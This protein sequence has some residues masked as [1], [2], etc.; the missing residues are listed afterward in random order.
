MRKDAPKQ[1]FYS[2]TP[3]NLDNQ[4]HLNRPRI[5]RLLEQ[6]V[7]NQVVIVSAGAGYGKTYA[8]YS[9]MRNYPALICWIQLSERDNISE[10]FWENFISGVSLG[11]KSAA[12]RL[13]TM[14]FPETDRQFERYWSIPK[15]ETRTDAKY[16]FIYD[17]FH[18]LQN[19]GVLRF[20]EQ[21]ITSP[22][23]NITSILISRTEPALDLTKLQV[24]GLVSR[25][26]EDDLRFTRE[27]MV[28]Y[29]H[30]QNI[31]PS[32]QTVAAIYDDAEGWAFA[33]HLAGLSLKNAAPGM[34]Y[35]PQAMRAN[36][37]KLIATEI[38]A[39][40]PVSLQRFLIKLSLIEH[41]APELLEKLAG[42]PS[43]L[44]EMKHLG[45]FIRFDMYR[46][47][48]H[49][50]HLLLDYLK[51]RQNELTEYDKKDLWHKAAGW[52]AANNQKM[53]A[54]SY[55]EKAGDYERL[56]GVITS[57]TPLLPNRIARMLLDIMERA[58]EEIYDQIAHAQVQRTGLYLLL[59]MFDKSREELLK[60]I[61]R[62]ETRPL[63]PTV[64]RTLTGCYNNLGFIGLN[65]CPYT[66]DYDYVHYF[67]KALYYY[68]LNKFETGPPITVIAISSY[69]CRVNTEERGE[70]E[71]Y[72]AAVSAFIPF[73][74]VT[75]GGC[76]LGM[77]DLCRGEL[78]FFKGDMAGAEQFCLRAL[79]G[80]RQGKQYD[81]ENRAL[82][83]LLRINL[84]RGASAA[85]EDILKQLKAQIDEP[86]YL[87]SSV[88]YDIVTGWYYAHTGQKDKV[89][90]WLKDDFEEGDFN[91]IIYGLEIMVKA[92]CHFSESQYPAALAVLESWEV[93]DSPWTFVLGKIE[94]RV[95]KAVCCYQLRDKQ[96]AFSALEQA[97]H[98]AQPN[99]LYLPFT[100]LG[101]DMRT[102]ADA[103]LKDPGLDIPRDWLEKVRLNAAA[104]ARKLFAVIGQ[105]SPAAARESLNRQGVKLSRREMEVL[106]NLAQGMTQEEIAGISSLS[107]N[108]VKS[109]IRSIYNKLG[110]INKADAVRIAAS[111]EILGTGG[112]NT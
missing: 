64:T 79:K 93:R 8:V 20:L 70:M 45:S 99:A 67:E 78:A 56:I 63:T 29:F 21:S 101:K 74:S 75:F 62:L 34:P 96:G 27:E 60:V 83:Y 112:K 15:E 80:A 2:N 76:G 6:A 36:I 9:F 31:E 104:Y 88:N 65:T 13:K 23:P 7:Q 108:T 12:E 90:P 98:L 82:F 105:G 102:L 55:Y 25:I 81:T 32:P 51:D 42:E 41:L 54:I 44:E 40:L 69:L 85:I 59:E 10:H 77:D 14:D 39:P 58:P 111:L 73:T 50:H 57:M 107:I 97:Y 26:T 33:I 5:D 66:R 18:L 87:T 11:N 94:G 110:A 16:I 95:L 35:I 49:I 71:R 43:L 19:K 37:F 28:T 106:T 92:K 100:E 52:C 48:Y 17:D 72:I 46:N 68:N 109:V 30:M 22:F 24:Q 84:A 103:A 89:A 53:D 38:M 3:I 86:Y 4:I 91:S 1:I 61:S 47:E